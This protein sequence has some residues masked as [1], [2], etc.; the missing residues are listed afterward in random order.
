MMP[1]FMKD[2][3]LTVGRRVKHMRDMASL[4]QV[5]ETLLRDQYATRKY[6]RRALL[7]P[8]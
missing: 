1:S 2:Y 3:F 8:S 7:S 6:R 4:A 5:S